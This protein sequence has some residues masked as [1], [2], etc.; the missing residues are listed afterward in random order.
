MKARPN[1]LILI[2][3]SDRLKKINPGNGPV[4]KSGTYGVVS[5]MVK[6]FGIFLLFI[7]VGAYAGGGIIENETDSQKVINEE[8][9]ILING[10]EQW[11]TIHGEVSKPVIL[12]LHGGPGSPISP[13]SATLYKNWEKEFIIVQWDQR[14]AGRTFGRTAPEELTPEYLRA[15]PLTI[16]QMVTDGIELAEYLLKTLQKNKLILF[17]TSWG[18]VL[19]VKMAVSRPELFYAYIGHSQVTDPAGDLTLYNKVYLLAEKNKDTA[20]VAL[21]N[22]IGIPP[23]DEAKNFGKLFRVVKKYE[24]LNSIPAP[25][26]WFVLS[27]PYDNAKDNRHRSDA[28]DYS[29]VNYAGDE[30]LGIIPMRETISLTKEYTVFKIPVYFIQGMEDLL[31]PKEA[32]RKYFDSIKAP[33]KKYYLLPKTAHGFN[34]SVLDAQYKICKEIRL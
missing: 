26:H 10:I 22:A 20:S 28:D 12:F 31:T 34:L 29:F 5:L 27:P 21:L 33:A 15:H 14:G 19:G 16:E 2:S 25:D 30:R 24:R 9:F 1:L 11:V 7:S 17:G 18:S 23:Y 13:Y 6:M 4:K 8:R 32:T 3:A